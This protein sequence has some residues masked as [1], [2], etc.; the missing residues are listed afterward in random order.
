MT[1]RPNYHLVSLGVSVLAT[2]G[3]YFPGSGLAAV[4]FLDG[5]TPPLALNSLIY[6]FIPFWMTMG[7]FCLVLIVKTA[8]FQV[9][10]RNAR[11]PTW[12]RADQGTTVRAMV[13]IGLFSVAVVTTLYW[14]GYMMVEGAKMTP[15]ASTCGTDFDLLCASAIPFFHF[16]WAMNFS[17]SVVIF[18][19]AYLA[20]AALSRVGRVVF[21]KP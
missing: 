19:S 20:G 4:S 12:R 21:Y 13:R 17:M 3:W 5:F 16:V 10:K 14:T 6:H 18:Y 7:L 15:V 2:V 8:V 9:L 1:V 11:G